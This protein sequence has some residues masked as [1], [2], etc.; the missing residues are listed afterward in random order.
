MIDSEIYT[1]RSLVMSKNNVFGIVKLGNKEFLMEFVNHSL[2][3]TDQRLELNE[4]DEFIKTL[5]KLAEEDFQFGTYNERLVVRDFHQNKAL[6]YTLEETDEFDRLDAATDYE[7][8]ITIITLFYDAEPFRQD[9][10]Q[11]V[12]VIDEQ[13]KFVDNEGALTYDEYESWFKETYKRKPKYP[14]KD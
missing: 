10:T 11:R 14:S 2:Q 5:E 4:V 7:D 1:L 9:R 13:N 6:V 3:R 12:V 8:K